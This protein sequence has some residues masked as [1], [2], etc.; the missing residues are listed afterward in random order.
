[1]SYFD[2]NILEKVGQRHIE[3]LRLHLE[4]NGIDQKEFSFAK[5]RVNKWCSSLLTVL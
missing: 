5:D 2:K 4:T 1:M 3:R